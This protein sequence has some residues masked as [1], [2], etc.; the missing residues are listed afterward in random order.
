MSGNY[1]ETTVRV[2][3]FKGLHSQSPFSYALWKSRRASN[4]YG[5]FETCF[6]PQP[7]FYEDAR[8]ESDINY[9]IFIRIVNLFEFL[10]KYRTTY[11][12]FILE[13]LLH[14]GA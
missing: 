3:D 9:L 14:I 5:A 1:L 6:S 4:Q 8:A 10:L 7:V 11:F 2:I 12:F 13:R